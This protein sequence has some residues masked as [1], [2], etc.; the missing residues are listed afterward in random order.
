M[1][2]AATGVQLADGVF[3]NGQEPGKAA[4]DSRLGNHS[5]LPMARLTPGR[6]NRPSI[7]PSDSLKCR[8]SSFFR[9]YGY[10]T[11]GSDRK[12]IRAVA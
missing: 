9:A 6:T 7:F 1:K 4:E 3:G 12:L 8:E 5:S 11:A 2:G 10:P